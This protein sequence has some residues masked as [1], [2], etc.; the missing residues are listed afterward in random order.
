MSY[1]NLFELPSDDRCWTNKSYALVL[2]ASLSSFRLFDERKDVLILV[3][4]EEIPTY[5]LSPYYRMRKMLKKKTY[6]S[7]PRAGEHIELFWEKLRQA[8]KI[9]EGLG[10]ERLQLTMAD[11]PWWKSRRFVVEY[12]SLVW[13]IYDIS[14]MWY[15]GHTMCTVLACLLDQL[16]LLINWHGKL[17]AKHWT[18][19][20]PPNWKAKLWLS[21]SVISFSTF[22]MFES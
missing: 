7:W 10:E 19:S 11:R 1:V 16:L 18:A 9:R 6:L 4:L 20:I 13:D 2:F 8:L 15:S 14:N 3:F 17:A 21:T 5:L 22:D 12:S